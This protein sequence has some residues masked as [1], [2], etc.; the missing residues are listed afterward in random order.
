MWAYIYVC[1]CELKFNQLHFQE[2]YE[3][4]KIHTHIQKHK[5]TY[6]SKSIKEKKKKS[7]KQEMGKIESY[8]P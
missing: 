3:N 1:V 5:H 7:L 4:L 6:I 2:H 8:E